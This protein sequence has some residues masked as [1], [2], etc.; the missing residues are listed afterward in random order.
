MTQMVMLDFD[1]KSPHTSE[2]FFVMGDIVSPTD[3]DALSNLASQEF[4]RLNP[5]A[6]TVHNA[7]AIIAERYNYPATYPTSDREET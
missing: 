2:I 5:Q 4:S 6:V 3:Y 7:I 1:V